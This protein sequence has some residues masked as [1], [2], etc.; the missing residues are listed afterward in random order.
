MGTWMD[1]VTRGWLIYQLTDSALQL[2]LVRGIQAIPF[3]VLSPLA[4]SAADRYSRRAQV[5]VAQFVNALVYAATAALIFF[6]AIR[7]WHVYVTAFIMAVV[8]VF[9]QPARAAM[10]SDAVPADNLTNAIGLNAVVFNVARSLGPALAGL[11]IAMAG[12]GGTYT[13]QAAFFLLA[14]FWT[15]RLRE[16]PQSAG[17]R[18]HFMSRESFGRSI[19]EGWKFSWSSEVVRAGL[20][21]VMFA[22]FFIVPFT[23]LLPVFARDLLNV[24]ATGQGLMLSAMG[25]GALCSAVLIASV[26]DRLPRGLIMLCGVGVYGVALIAF[27]TSSWFHLSLVLMAITGLCHVHA[28]ALVQTVIQAYSPSTLRGRTMALFHMSQVVMTAGSMLVGA[29]SSTLGARW[30]VGLTGAAGTLSM[31]AVHMLMPRARHIR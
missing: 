16:L 24:G 14:T 2:G 31:L 6:D 13:V 1:Q 12:T 4:G 11:I 30:A 22:N 20:L 3:L 5:I 17:G 25:I 29:L 18:A 21:V 15:V 19:L 26:G 27:S 7:P 10:V 23:T 8:Q 9:Q 28:H